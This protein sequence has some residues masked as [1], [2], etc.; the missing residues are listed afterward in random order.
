MDGQFCLEHDAPMPQK[1]AET[2]PRQHPSPPQFY[3]RNYALSLRITHLC[4]TFIKHFQE[5]SFSGH[6]VL[7]WRIMHLCSIF[8][9]HFRE[10][11]SSGHYVLSLRIV[12]LC[13]IFHQAFWG[14]FVEWALCSFIKDSTSLFN[15]HQAFSGAFGSLC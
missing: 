12:H 10:P 11:L 8:L 14:A 6:Y 13:S 15:L 1:L 9:K 5:P 2:W 7:P 3:I 4:S